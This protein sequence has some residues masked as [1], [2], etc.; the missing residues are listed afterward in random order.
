MTLLVILYRSALYS[1]GKKKKN[2]T[3]KTHTKKDGKKVLVNSV[4]HKKIL[5]VIL[6]KK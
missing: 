1:Q 2:K 4:S 3:Q 6:K 5:D